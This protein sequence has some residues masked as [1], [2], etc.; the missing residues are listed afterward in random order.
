MGKEVLVGG[1]WKD[2][3]DHQVR[4]IPVLGG[5]SGCDAW[6]LHAAGSDTGNAEGPQPALP[7]G[8]SAQT[9]LFS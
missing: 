6:K 9:L 8:L 1:N 3:G 7:A 2:N 5:N 4:L